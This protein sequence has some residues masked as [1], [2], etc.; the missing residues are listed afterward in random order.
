MNE[1]WEYVMLARM[2]NRSLDRARRSEHNIIN[3]MK[4]SKKHVNILPNILTNF[5]V[6]A[7]TCNEWTFK[8]WALSIE[9]MKNVNENILCKGI[10]YGIQLFISILFHNL[11]SF[12]FTQ[13]AHKFFLFLCHKWCRMNIFTVINGTKISQNFSPKMA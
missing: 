13:T 1:L 9:W 2:P 5:Y 4:W 8:H 3:W 10:A 11:I 7:F 12:S 6:S